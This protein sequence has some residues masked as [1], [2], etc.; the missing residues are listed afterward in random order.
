MPPRGEIEHAGPVIAWIV[1]VGYPKVEL[2]S[3]RA[4]DLFVN[5]YRR[6]ILL[7]YHSYPR[8]LSLEDPG[9]FQSWPE[10]RRCVV[11]NASDI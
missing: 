6:P 9:A 5:H 1:Q 7:Y 2:E 11:C 10:I 4:E 3:L 8:E